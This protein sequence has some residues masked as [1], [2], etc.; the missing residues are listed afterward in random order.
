[1]G[2]NTSSD[3]SAERD[4][5]QISKPRTLGHA[6][7]TPKQ[8]PLSI[9]QK[10]PL[11]SQIDRS[12]RRQS[13][14]RKGSL[15]T[16]ETA[17]TMSTKF[18]PEHRRS[19]SANPPSSQEYRP[20][21]PASPPPYSEAIA[22]GP[23]SPA[24]GQNYRA[25]S[26]ANNISVPTNSGNRRT[27]LHSRGDRTSQ[28]PQGVLSMSSNDRISQ[29]QA[30]I[31]AAAPKDTRTAG[32]SNGSRHTHVAMIGSGSTTSAD[33]LQKALGQKLLQNIGK[34]GENPLEQLAGYNT[35]FVVDDSTSMRHS[36]W[37]EVRC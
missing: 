3:F 10:S 37:D 33:P 22:T 21:L 6:K 36:L 12:Q 2:N 14:S 18:V 11:S 1:M 29:L 5:S 23:M 25:R 4:P 28:R 34:S 8:D 7:D 16:Q 24:P 17:A 31:A 26:N 30:R 13:L 35:V 15:H 20:V 9:H 27:S 19:K 32:L